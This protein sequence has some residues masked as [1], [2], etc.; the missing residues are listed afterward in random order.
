MARAV[1]DFFRFYQF[2]LNFDQEG[3]INA[4]RHAWRAVVARHWRV[5]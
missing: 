1:A 3:R 4:A 5:K 2:R